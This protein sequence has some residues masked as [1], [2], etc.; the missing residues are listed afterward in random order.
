[1]KRR[2]T[3]EQNIKK[4]QEEID[5]LEAEANAIDNKATKSEK[6]QVNGGAEQKDSS[7]GEVSENL[8]KSTLEEKPAA[9][10]TTA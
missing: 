4:A 6:P 2:L 5:R 10:S 7:V 3:H 1:M 9:G 8:E